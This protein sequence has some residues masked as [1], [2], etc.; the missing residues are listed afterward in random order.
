VE[1]GVIVFIVYI[2]VSIF[3]ARKKKEDKD[4]P[5]EHYDRVRENIQRA[6]DEWI[7]QNEAQATE[8]RS[9]EASPD[10]TVQNQKQAQQ[11]P[12]A[13]GRRQAAGRTTGA[14]QPQP[15]LTS[16]GPKA[17]Q[18]LTF[19]TVQ[20]RPAAGQQTR[21]TRKPGAG[22]LSGDGQPVAVETQPTAVETQPAMTTIPSIT[23]PATETDMIGVPLPG[24]PQYGAAEE[25]R[26]RL[27]VRTDAAAVKSA[28]PAQRRMAATGLAEA[29]IWSQ[30]LGL[31]K[32]RQ[33]AYGRPGA[34][35]RG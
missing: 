35:R 11:Q 33:I 2:V 21:R 10:K 1:I 12:S 29:M 4:R 16:P 3:N 20:R 6:K 19:E 18:A 26:A 25:T 31:P 22:R 30:I 34:R 7:A 17:G 5:K 14:G 15:P 32:G 27:R 8:A 13:A 24:W 23:L 28:D 9:V